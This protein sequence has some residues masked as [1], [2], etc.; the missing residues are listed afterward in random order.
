VAFD[1]SGNPAV[2]YVASSTVKFAHIVSGSWTTETIDSVDSNGMSLAWDGSTWVA[3]YGNGLLKFAKRNPTTGA[4]STQTVE[5]R[6]VYCTK[7]IAVYSSG[8]TYRIGISYNKNSLMY[9]EY[10][11]SSWTKTIVDRQSDATYTSLAFDSTGQPAIAYSVSSDSG[12]KYAKRSSG[13]WATQTVA[14]YGYNSGWQADIDLDSSDRPYIT[15]SH[16]WVYL[17]VKN[18]AGGWDVDVASPE[19]E[20]WSA[21]LTLVESDGTVIPYIVYSETYTDNM[22]VT[23]RIDG[24]WTAEILEL[25]AEVVVQ[26]DIRYYTDGDGTMKLGVSYDADRGTGTDGITYAER[27]L[28]NPST[29]G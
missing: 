14:A 8:S 9:A 26:A 28:N 23:A 6:N 4:W 11:G 2:I 25:D 3:A 18:D 17:F 1:D 19:K 5:A 15:C 21:A 20:A 10:G 29:W 22:M 13:T 12:L 27:D 24:K 7:S 16:H